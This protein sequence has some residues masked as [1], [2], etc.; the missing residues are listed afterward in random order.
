[1]SRAFT[2]LKK[3]SQETSKRVI[4]TRLEAL[5]LKWTSIQERHNQIKEIKTK[6][7]NSK[8][9]FEGNLIEEYEE[10]YFEE[11]AKFLDALEELKPKP[12]PGGG[13]PAQMVEK[14]TTPRKLPAM[15]LPQFSGK[16]SDWSS[17][18]DM[19]SAFMKHDTDLQ[20]VERLY[21]LKSCLSGEPVNLLKNI[22]V[23]DDN[24]TRAWARLQA[25]YENKRALIN[26]CIN[27]FLDLSPVQCESHAALKTLRDGTTEVIE[28][29]RN[30]ERP[31]DQMDDFFV[32]LTVRRLDVSTRRDWE[33]SLGD[34]T[35]PTTWKQLDTFLKSR[36]QALEMTSVQTPALS[37]DGLSRK[38]IPSSG[39]KG[40]A[41][42]T[43]HSVSKHVRHCPYCQGEHFISA[44]DK[45]R[46]CS[47]DNR[48]SFVAE[49]KLC[50]NCLGT[51][52]ITKCRSTG[53]CF[54][55]HNQHNSLLHRSS[56]SKQSTA[57]FQR[58]T[59]Q[60][61]Q[62]SSNCNQ[63][64]LHNAQQ[65]GITPHQS[66]L[67]PA[68][69]SGPSS[70]TTAPQQTTGFTTHATRAPL[71]PRSTRLLATA[72]VF[73]TSTRNRVSRARALIDPCSEATFVSEALAKLI[74]AP[75]QSDFAPVSG[76]GALQSHKVK[77][78]T[79]ISISPHFASDNSW[80]MTALILP[81]I[82]EYVPSLKHTLDA[83]AFLEGLTLADPEM[84]YTDE[85]DLIIAADTY[86]LLIEEGLRK[87]PGGD[88]VAQTTGLGW[89]LTGTQLSATDDL[90]LISSLP[91][92]T[93]EDLS[94]LLTSFWQQ[95]EA[96]PADSAP[97]TEDER[98][99]EEH[100]AETHRRRADGR[101][102]LHL[103][104]KSNLLELG[105]SKQAAISALRRTEQRMM[106]QPTYSVEYNKFM[107][108][109]LS[110]G[111]MKVFS[112]LEFT[113]SSDSPSFYLPHHVQGSRSHEQ[114][115]RRF[116]WLDQVGFRAPPQ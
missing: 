88:L 112:P 60:F 107:Q 114:A 97:L 18:K 44:C 65:Q 27:S 47:L 26:L 93:N 98:T 104:F 105:D 55:C 31:V 12:T 1:M 19:F 62:T 56:S 101:Y 29:L 72:R 53:T 9:Y 108:D 17:F 43:A 79:I 39:R 8:L 22:P 15:S 59:L 2:N 71:Q 58:P 111:H 89:I 73:V 40:T 70:L 45:F 20:E 86:P 82:T 54:L 113:S 87:A 50:T 81:R 94:D 25:H 103:P 80:R 33:L 106:R 74:K 77:S 90:H 63:S 35:T 3:K 30:L 102:I 38:G 21:Y 49:K 32:N 7:D 37:R 23:T 10:T 61:N 36:I 14:R 11:K 76:V 46:S 92:V 83:C 66:A 95:E 16:Y 67:L 34:T 24:Y 28:T 13:S 96:M 78:K 115:A 52:P 75:R 110:L 5:E 100:F 42:V 57:R 51:H 41:R 64:G 84:N 6:A 68:A 91:C 116:Q 4:Q 109:Y 99:C 69:P 48:H 85:I